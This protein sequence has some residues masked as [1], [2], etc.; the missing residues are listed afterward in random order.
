MDTVEIICREANRL[1]ENLAREVLDFIEYLQFKHALTDPSIDPM[2]A[3]Q[4][5]VMDGIWDNSEDEVWNEL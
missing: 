1:P 5:K 2:R 3:A 4:T